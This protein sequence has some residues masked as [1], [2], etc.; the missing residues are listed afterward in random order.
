MTNPLLQGALLWRLQ[1]MAESAVQ[2]SDG[3]KF[4]HQDTEA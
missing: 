1:T 3:I 4:R 2:L